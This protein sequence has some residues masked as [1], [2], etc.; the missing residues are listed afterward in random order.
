MIRFF[1][2]STF[3]DMQGERDAIH[4]TM[5]PTIRKY[6]LDKGVNVDICDLRWGIDFDDNWSEEEAI[7][8][9]MKVCFKEVKDCK[10]HIISMIGDFYGS[11]AKNPESIISLWK[12]FG[13]KESEL[14]ENRDISLTQ[15][16]LE[17]YARIMV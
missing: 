9:I 15:W 7:Q 10:P 4:R 3:R 17:S 13:R 2:S 12:D 6:G 16:E 1:I 11:K 14:P 8:E 5:F